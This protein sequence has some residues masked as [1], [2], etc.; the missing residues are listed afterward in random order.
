MQDQVVG[1]LRGHRFGEVIALAERAAELDQAACLLGLLDALGD[2]GEVE[3]IRQ[4]QDRAQDR[5][6]GVGLAD[7]VDEGL[8]DLEVVE[9]QLL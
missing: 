2:G 5:R 6:L 3:H 9:G 7:L 4:V 1:G 8:S